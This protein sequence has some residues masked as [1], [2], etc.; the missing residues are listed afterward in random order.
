MPLEPT[1]TIF[2]P[3]LGDTDERLLAKL[4]YSFNRPS[5]RA[6]AL[7]SAART[8]STS[9]NDIICQ[10][11]SGIGIWINCTVAGAAGGLTLYLQSQDPVSGNWVLS[12]VASS[13]ISTVRTTSVFLG[14]GISQGNNIS[15]PTGQ[16]DRGI[17]LPESIRIYVSAAT[18]DSYTYSVGYELI[19]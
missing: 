10:G 5:I 18:A 19:P 1:F 16:G 2:R 13:A 7:A 8:S 14:R 11:Y 9:S 17:L 3:E 12:Y 15:L 6:T 4:L